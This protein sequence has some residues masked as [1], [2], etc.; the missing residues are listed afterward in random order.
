M[1]LLGLGEILDGLHELSFA[2]DGGGFGGG[3]RG[4]LLL[5]LSLVSVGFNLNQQRALL[6]GLPFDY[7]DGDDFTGDFGRNFNFRLGLDF[8]RGGDELGDGLDHSFFDGDHLAYIGFFIFK[9]S[10]GAEASDEQEGADDDV[11]RLGFFDGSRRGSGDVHGIF[12]CVR[13]KNEKIDD[14]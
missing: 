2:E 7:G 4:L 11:F 12:S 9:I 8:T 1:E 6:D 14:Y 3:E 5:E 10:R 13:L